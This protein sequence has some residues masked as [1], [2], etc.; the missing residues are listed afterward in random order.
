MAIEQ[1]IDAFVQ[2]IQCATTQAIVINLAGAQIV[3]TSFDVYYNAVTSKL[4]L[5]MMLTGKS[6][7]YVTRNVSQ[8]TKTSNPQKWKNNG[9]SNPQRNNKRGNNIFKP[10]A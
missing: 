7:N 1:Q 8:L 3:R 9:D 6:N 4:E 5:V 10:E 2:G